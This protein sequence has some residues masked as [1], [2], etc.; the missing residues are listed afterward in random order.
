MRLASDSF[1]DDARAR[2]VK[3]VAI[4]ESKTSAEIVPVVA[5]A[6][7]RYD[8]AEDIAGLFVGAISAAV[9][10]LLFEEYAPPAADWGFS[11]STLKLP[12]MLLA[13][14]AGF[15][16]GAFV[17]SRVGLLRALFTPRAQ[18]RD[19]VAARARAVFFDSRIHHTEG[20]TGVLVFVSLHERL[21]AVISDKAVAEKVG[22]AALDEVRD[23]LVIGL[24]AGALTDAI[25]AAVEAA[26][27]KLGPVLPREEADVNE[28]PDAL[29]L[30][31]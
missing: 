5:T 29:V 25:C 24:R 22:Q 4:A 20:Q 30:L 16:L 11:L 6:S 19:E 28:L 26:G 15:V 7:G 13:L 10:W 12:A 17:A 1:S 3:A 18:M 2:I 21:A 31:D 9:A 23:R 27:E 8:R 14:V